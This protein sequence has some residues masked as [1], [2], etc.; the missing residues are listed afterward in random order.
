M[1]DLETLKSLMLRAQEAKEA[2]RALDEAIMAA[3]YVRDS[4]HIG[5]SDY[6]TDE[7]VKDDVWVDPRTDKW[8]TNQTFRFTEEAGDVRRL[9]CFLPGGWRLH[10][11]EPDPT[12]EGFGGR[13]WAKISPHF[14]SAEA[15][16]IGPRDCS[17][18][19][20]PLALT[21]AALMLHAS[22]LIAQAEQGASR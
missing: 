7:P 1:A 9:L 17:A 19:T 20:L 6:Y 13:A 2:D 21:A 22:A 11:S 5:A 15:Q 16:E 10:T 18:P 8:V 14:R 12:A 4:R 3:F